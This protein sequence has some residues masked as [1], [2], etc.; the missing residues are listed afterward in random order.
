MAYVRSIEL[1]NTTSQYLTRDN[2]ALPAY[3]P[4]DPGTGAA[5]HGPY[6]PP[7]A[8]AAV[9][10][11]HADT[12]TLSQATQSLFESIASTSDAAVAHLLTTFPHPGLTPNSRSS[13]GKTALAAAVESG[14]MR[15]VE[16]LINLG[17]DVN[18]WSVQGVYPLHKLY[19][20]KR[21]TAWF[22]R[23]KP[24]PKPRS[25]RLHA[26]DRGPP[27]PPPPFPLHPE[28]QILRTP[29]M[30][31]ASRGLLAIAKLLLN[32]PCNAD[33]TLCA[34]D[35]Q[36]ALRLAA[37]HHHR[38]LV[39]L[40]PALRRGGLRR[41]KHQH[42]TSAYRIAQTTEVARQVARFLVWSLPKAF[43]YRLPKWTV[44][45][46][47]RIARHIVMVAI[48]GVAGETWDLTRR[49]ARYIQHD[50]PAALLR[51]GALAAHGVGNF[52]SITIPRAAS[53][54]ARVAWNLLSRDIPRGLLA[55]A[56]FLWTLLTAHIPRGIWACGKGVWYTLAITAWFLK[57][58]ATSWF[59]LF[60]QAVLRELRAC[61]AATCALAGRGARAALSLL[62]MVFEAVAS[63]FRRVSLGDVLRGVGEVVRWLVVEVPRAG[64][65]AAARVYWGGVKLVEKVFGLGGRVAVAVWHVLVFVVVYFPVK[66]AKAGGEYGKVLGRG[67]REVGV[68]FDPKR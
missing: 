53:G 26:Y 30:I 35:G 4:T 42:A 2:E 37:E 36:I 50:L 29:L 64:A 52:L 47:W 59:P 63:F 8:A 23:R 9:L 51:S 11:A 45:R 57:K 16:M 25:E 31:A 56:R 48:P 58:L 68:W 21:R 65:R 66:V 49:T 10:A 24:K 34:P 18:G 62:H 60:C 22:R 7:S 38:E 3:T 61:A 17:A 39:A 32:P 6:L 40:L 33:H 1:D 67:C 20:E 12:A 19:H 43:L 46:L 5:L 54:T 27:G 15:M 28:Y 55:T 41:F 14:N 44:K 13:S